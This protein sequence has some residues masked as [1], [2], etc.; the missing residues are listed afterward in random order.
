MACWQPSSVQVM[1]QQCGLHVAALHCAGNFV[2]DGGAWCHWAVGA[3]HDTYARNLD[4]EIGLRH[5][6]YAATSAGVLHIGWQSTYGSSTQHIAIVA[7]FMT[8]VCI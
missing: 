2:T 1:L 4:G 5:C 7:T 3:Q 6:T 8:G